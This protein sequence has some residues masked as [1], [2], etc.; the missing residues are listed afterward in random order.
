MSSSEASAVATVPPAPPAVPPAAASVARRASVELGAHGFEIRS[1]AQLWEVAEFIARSE[2]RPAGLRTAADCFLVMAYGQMYEFSEMEALQKL[3]VVKG[4]VCIGAEGMVAKIQ[5]S[6]LCE[7][8]RMWCEGEGEQ[9]VGCVQSKRRGRPEANPIERFSIA[10]ARQARLYDPQWKD[11]NGEPSVWVKYP[12]DQVVWKAAARDYRH[13]WPDAYRAPLTPYEDLRELEHERESAAAPAMSAPPPASPALQALA[14]GPVEFDL[15][16]AAERELAT[17]ERPI[18]EGATV[19]PSA[20]ASESPKQLTLDAESEP[21]AEPF[22]GELSQ[23]LRDAIRRRAEV[24]L[25]DHRA[26]ATAD[27][28]KMAR[29]QLGAAKPLVSVLTAVREWRPNWGR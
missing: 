3:H 13:N 17:L 25:P 9:L 7:W 29:E 10:D 6:P 11:R 1:A 24:M 23:G 19:Y 21:A 20:R 26:R 16:S 4:K 28:E 12:R 2:L 15:R 8:H 14:A 22:A 27:L 18:A 5:A